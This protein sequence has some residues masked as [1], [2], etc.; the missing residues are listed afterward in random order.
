MDEREYWNARYSARPADDSGEPNAFL[1][2]HLAMLPRGHVL[3]LAMGEGHNAVFFAKQG[4]RVTGIDVSDAAVERTLSSARQARVYLEARREDLC[5]AILPANTYDVIACFNY[6]QR[7]LWP[8]I[9][10]ALRP[11]GMVI[12]ETFSVDQV[13]YGHPTDRRYLLAPNE[14]IEAFHALRIR[15]Y[16]DLVV[17]GPKAVASLIAEKTAL[18]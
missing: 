4:Y 1:R 15:I 12:Y 16:R 13:R 5:S 7:S 6:L 11:G 14:L 18:P 8:Q 3:E 17:Y 10:S 2:E 9:I